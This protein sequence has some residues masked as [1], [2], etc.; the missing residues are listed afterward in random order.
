MLVS[1]YFLRKFIIKRNI[2]IFRD[3]VFGE[4]MR[5]IK[6]ETPPQ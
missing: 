2:E 5:G 3:L 1:S 4:K 6:K